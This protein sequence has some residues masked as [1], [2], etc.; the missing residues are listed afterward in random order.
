MPLDPS[1]ED[2]PAPPGLLP[3]VLDGLTRMVAVDMEDVGL[4]GVGGV[5]CPWLWLP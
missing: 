1:L 4:D 5:G 3:L 2:E